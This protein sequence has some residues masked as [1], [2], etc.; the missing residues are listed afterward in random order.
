MKITG[1]LVTAL[2]AVGGAVTGHGIEA[3]N[4]RHEKWMADSRARSAESARKHKEYMDGHNKQMRDISRRARER[5]RDAD[6]LMRRIEHRR[7]MANLRSSAGKVN[8]RTR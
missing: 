8:I 4:D 5:R 6:A 7:T 3:D 1:P 2:L